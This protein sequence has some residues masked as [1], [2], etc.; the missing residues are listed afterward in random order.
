MNR[1]ERN[2][3]EAQTVTLSSDRV[4]S[5]R[6]ATEILNI[7]TP[8]LMKLICSKVIR[9]NKLGGRWFITGRAILDA[10][11]G[12]AKKSLNSASTR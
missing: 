3:Q 8:T 5:L 7:S 1:I 6:E 11:D 4:Y 10:L 12:H 2:K 9:A